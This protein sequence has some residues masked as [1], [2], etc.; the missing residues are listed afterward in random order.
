VT[1]R[2][3]DSHKSKS[4]NTDIGQAKK[5]SKEE[6]EEGKLLYTYCL[7]EICF[8]SALVIPAEESEW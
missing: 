1:V 3:K 4:I 7:T 2:E 6:P 5:A 8:S